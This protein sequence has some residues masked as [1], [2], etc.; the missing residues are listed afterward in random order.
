VLLH[1][2]DGVLDELGL[3]A[4]DVDVVALGGRASSLVDALFDVVD[5]LDRVGAALLADVED[6]VERLPRM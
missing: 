6:T 1:G 4:R 5:D 3:I 2:A